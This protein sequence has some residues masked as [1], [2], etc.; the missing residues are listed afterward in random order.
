[1][2][3]TPYLADIPSRHFLFEWRKRRGL[4]QDALGK[5]VGTTGATISRLESDKLGLEMEMALKLFDALDILP[6]QFF[7]P[8]GVPHLDAF[9]VGLSP[10]R[11]RQLLQMVKEF[12][13]EK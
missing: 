2:A 8:P 6:G 4:T 5:L 11:R 13:A 9:A 12:V 7:A 10:Q 3:T 1:M